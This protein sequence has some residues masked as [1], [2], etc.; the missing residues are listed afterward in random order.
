MAE[1]TGTSDELV[2]TLNA[3]RDR[4][5][6]ATIAMQAATLAAVVR[7]VDAM[8]EVSALATG[9]N[10]PARNAAASA[11]MKA[12]LDAVGSALDTLA[13]V[14]DGGEDGGA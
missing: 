7:F 12:T 6:P 11:A 2:K 1:T 3:L 4:T 8:I 13:P 10:T 14:V 9:D 5:E